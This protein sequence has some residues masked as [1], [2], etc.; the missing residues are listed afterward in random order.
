MEIIIG[1][2]NYFLCKYL[3][4]QKCMFEQKYDMDCNTSIDH[5]YWIENIY[6]YVQPSLLKQ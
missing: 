1:H 3:I 2:S 5:T 4:V 6:T